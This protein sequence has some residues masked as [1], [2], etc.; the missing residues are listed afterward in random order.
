MRFVVLL[1][2]LQDLDR[3]ELD[4]TCHDRDLLWGVA[5]VNDAG[6]KP[7][8]FLKGM[9]QKGWKRASRPKHRLP[10]LLR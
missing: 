3:H 9:A 5:K 1:G 7:L 10:R 4:V 6:V 2:A 8:I